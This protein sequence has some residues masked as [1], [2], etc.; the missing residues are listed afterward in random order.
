M[1]MDRFLFIR[2]NISG[3]HKASFDDKDLSEGPHPFHDE[4][5]RKK[6]NGVFLY[7]VACET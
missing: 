2:N 1:T 5:I 7:I 6:K 3:G 4:T